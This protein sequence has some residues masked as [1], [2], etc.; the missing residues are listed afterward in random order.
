MCDIPSLTTPSLRLGIGPEHKPYYKDFLTTTDLILILSR[1]CIYNKVYEIV[2][3]NKNLLRYITVEDKAAL[4]EKS[5]MKLEEIV[6]SIKNW[7]YSCKREIGGIKP[8]YLSI[9]CLK[10]LL[11][12]TALKL[13]LEPLCEEKIFNKQSFGFRPS[14]S[15]HLALYTVKKMIGVTWMVQGRIK[16][17]YDSIDHNI[18]I[19]IINKKIGLDRTLKGIFHKFLKAGYLVNPYYNRNQ[20]P[21]CSD[22]ATEYDIISSLLFNIY[23]TPLDEFI[24]GLKEKHGRNPSN[25]IYYVRFADSWLIGLEGKEDSVVAKNISEEIRIFL[26]DVLKLDLAGSAEAPRLTKCCAKNKVIYLGNGYAEFLG[27]KFSSPFLYQTSKKPKVSIASVKKKKLFSH[28][29]SFLGFSMVEG[30]ITSRTPPYFISYDTLSNSNVNFSPLVLIPIF[31][32]KHKL[33]QKGFADDNGHPKYM[34]KFLHLSDY[35]I[36]NKYNSVITKIMTYYYVADNRY[37]LS[38]IIYILEYSL[39]HTLAAKHRWTLAKVFN[40]YGKPFVVNAGGVIKFDK[41]RSLESE[42]LN[43]KYGKVSADVERWNIEYRTQDPISL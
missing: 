4:D 9:P 12:Q 35:E 41:P 3:S 28:N 32:L 16:S 11:V 29:S 39:A 5:E 6:L 21:V 43:N 19:S 23:L 31:G 24:D 15:V 38:E 37:R 14:R 13:L 42:Y 18:L 20:G 33:I 17:F 27:H 26:R 7:T 30:R 22:T 1:P 8:K 34:G 25:R 36:V 2:K 40:E 10:D